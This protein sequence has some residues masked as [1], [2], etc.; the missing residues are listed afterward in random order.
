MR[1][2][3]DYTGYAFKTAYPPLPFRTLAADIKHVYS[4]EMDQG[5]STEYQEHGG[6]SE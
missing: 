5:V 2:T 6:E 3:E 1:R 4:A